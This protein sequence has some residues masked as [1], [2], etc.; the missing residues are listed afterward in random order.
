MESAFQFTNPALMDLSFCI[1]ENFDNKNN[2]EVQIGMKISIKVFKSNKPNEASV[3]L[4]V[5]IGEKDERIPFWI[6]GTEAADFKWEEEI[7]DSMSERLLKQNAPS[8]LLS[9]LRPIIA[10]VTAASSYGIY[11]IPFINFAKK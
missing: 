9:Y 1:N 2:S 7:D 11:N 5:E 4:T 3:H 10:Q 8:L 6:K